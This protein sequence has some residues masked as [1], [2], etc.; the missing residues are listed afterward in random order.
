MTFARISIR[1]PKATLES[2]RLNKADALRR[3]GRDSAA[4]LRGPSSLWP[5]DT[6]RSKRAWR[7]QRGSGQTITDICGVEYAS[8]VEARTGAGFR[9]LQAWR[10]AVVSGHRRV[11][12]HADTTVRLGARPRPPRRAVPFARRRPVGRQGFTR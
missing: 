4:Y 9:S 8:F 2:E 1:I 5:V 7:Y 12:Q 3:L 10:R 11:R 6:G